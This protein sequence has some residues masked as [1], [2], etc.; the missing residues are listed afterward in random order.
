MKTH[1][2]TKNSRIRGARTCGW[3]FRQKHKG[4]GNKGGFGM[5]GSGKRADHKKQK[6]L[7]SDKK[8]LYFGRQGL[9]S[10]RT[11]VKK[12]EKINLA[13][14]GANLFTKDGCSIDLSKHK[15][16]GTG[17]GFKATIIAKSASANAVEKMSKAGGKI[18]L[19]EEKKSVKQ[20]LK[21]KK[22]GKEI[23]EE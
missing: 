17:N 11:M 8:K 13:D 18:I 2:R 3:G 6:A 16:L 22:S 4:H 15:I 10:R 12:Y 20:Y 9:T 14:I 19:P 5:A 7:E 21:G 1:K 23:N